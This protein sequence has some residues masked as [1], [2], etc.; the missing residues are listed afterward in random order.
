MDCSY[1]IA[2][3][4]DGTLTNDRKEITPRTRELLI[5]LQR[6]G[7]RV[8]LAS[9]RPPYG[10][11][12]LAE[13]LR[14][15]D[16]GGVLLC[17]NG[18]Y[19]E[20][21][22]TGKVLTERFL[23][24]DI[25]GHD[26]ALL[27]RLH[28]WQQKTGMTLMTY[29]EDKIYT[30]HPDDPYVAQSSR[31]NKMRVVGVKDFLH[32]VPR[33]VNKCLIVGSPEL[34]KKWEFDMAIDFHARLHI[35]HS[36]PYFIEILPLHIDKGNAL[37]NLLTHYGMTADRLIAFGDSH[38]DIGMLTAAGIGVAMGNAEEEVKQAADCITQSN[39]ED[40]V[41]HFL[42]RYFHEALSPS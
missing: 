32:N 5:T 7:A 30:E 15:G 22:S 23:G 19:I 11:R 39:E 4:L 34:V 18:G 25:P 42:L 12:P 2:L 36:T 24:D 27:K 21:C 6:K 16:Y 3:D 28:M 8:C 38:N 9:G 37:K 40:G 31:N 14:M 26:D 17:Y 41:Y 33:P 13:Q 29:H 1:I 10:M 20:E 35:L